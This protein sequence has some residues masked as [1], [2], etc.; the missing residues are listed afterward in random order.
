MTKSSLPME[1]LFW[2]D[3]GSVSVEAAIKMA[4]QYQQGRKCPERNT[5]LA[6]LGGYHG[7]TL[8]AMS[9]CDPV[10]GMHTLF[11]GVVAK[12]HFIPRPSCVF[13]GD[14]NEP[15]DEASLAPLDE[16]FTL[17]KDSLA[18]VIIEPIV[19][20]AGGMWFYHP[21][22]LMRLRELCTKHEVLLIFDEIATAFG[23]TGKLFAAEWAGISPDI[24][25]V[26]KGLT[27]GFMTLAATMCTDHVA[28][29]ICNDGHVL[30]R[31]TF[32]GNPLATAVANSLEVLLASPWQERVK[33]IENELYGL[34]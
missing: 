24:I 6:P 4:L 31:P 19:Q 8:G 10:N 21:K 3:S 17:H 2:A 25:C 33:R 1:R 9:V 22:Y 13:S 15:F 29:A 11:S 27:G 12:Q 26:G 34:T 28:K 16:A 5:I 7:D 30:C 20:G 32:M 18:A 23:R 14:I